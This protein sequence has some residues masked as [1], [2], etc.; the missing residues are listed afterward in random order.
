MQGRNRRTPGQVLLLGVRVEH[1][2]KRCEGVSPAHLNG[3]GSQSGGQ[4]GEP[5]A[6]AHLLAPGRM[7]QA[8]LQPGYW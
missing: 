1:N 4:E 5:A 8:C 7:V 3:T 6:G 2:K